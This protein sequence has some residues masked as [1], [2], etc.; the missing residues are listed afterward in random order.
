M[1]VWITDGP[2]WHKM[3]NTILRTFGEID[4]AMNYQILDETFEKIISTL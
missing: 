4:F 2:G 1:L 3:K